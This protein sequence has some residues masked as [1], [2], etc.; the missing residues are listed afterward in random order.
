MTLGKASVPHLGITKTYFPCAALK[1]IRTVV[2][3]PLVVGTNARNVRYFAYC[4]HVALF[5]EQFCVA[6]MM[7]LLL[8]NFPKDW[9]LVSGSVWI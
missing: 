8:S 1:L 7:I 5:T 9:K 2:L 4:S 6:G 3:L